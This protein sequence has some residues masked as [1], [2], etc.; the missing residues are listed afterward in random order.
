MPEN[1]GFHQ[2][3]FTEFRKLPTTT[4]APPKFPA[5]PQAPIIT[6]YTRMGRHMPSDKADEKPA[7]RHEL[8]VKAMQAKQQA[9]AATKQGDLL[10]GIAE[11][12]TKAPAAPPKAKPKA[13]ATKPATTTPSMRK[14]PRGAADQPDFFAPML[15]DVGAKDNRG[16]MD[17]AVY[18]LSKRDKR[19]N[20]VMRYELTDGFVQVASGAYGMASVWDYD[21]VLMAISHLT[22]AMNRYAEGTGEKPPQVFR[23]HISDVLKFCRKDNGGAQKAFVVDALN[24]L[25]TT[26][27]SM[28]RLMMK[29][30]ELKMVNE[31][32]NLIGAT[33]VISNVKTKKVEYVEFKIAD[34]MYAEI[35]EGDK[36]DVLTVHPDYFLLDAGIGRF[37]YRLARKAAGK[38]SARWGFRT[39][40]ERSGS[41]GEFKEFTRALREI[42]KA[43]DLPEYYLTEED[44][45]EGQVLCMAHRS[46]ADKWKNVTPPAVGSDAPAEVTE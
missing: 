23:P 41:T 11:G 35:T 2:D 9:R 6:Q 37:L 12:A 22:E 34:W 36:P 7:N 5:E 19:A 42:I 10:A 30:G 32:D 45:L 8:V 28:E 43:N 44:G 20:E 21:L 39:I 17:V 16:V 24:R 13:P 14:R 46:Q 31:S 29:D 33:K 4:P 3:G 40:F 18:R 27:V 25:S 1:T 38:T 26:H 15:Y